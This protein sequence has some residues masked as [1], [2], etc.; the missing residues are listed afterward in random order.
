MRI[1]IASVALR[2]Q[3]A[4]DVA[5]SVPLASA[6]LASEPIVNSGKASSDLT[7]LVNHCETSGR[8]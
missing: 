2:D 1:V 3:T 6:V 7:S 5:I 8:C 4:V